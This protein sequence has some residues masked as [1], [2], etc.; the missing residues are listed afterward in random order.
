[1]NWNNKN[2]LIT[3]GAGFI[4]SNLAKYLLQNKANVTIFDNFS[5]SN[6]E[7]NLP[8]LENVAGSLQ[9]IRGDVRD[10]LAVT[11][12]VQEKD[13]IFHEAAQVAVTDSVANPIE[14]FEINARG[15]LNVL[16]AMREHSPDA[17]FVFASTNKV[18][19]G[20]E[21]FQVE[22]K[23]GRYTFS[24]EA[25]LEGVSEEINLDFHSPYGC[26]KGSADQYVRDFS[27]IYGLKTLVFR[28][29]CIY[30]QRQWGTEDQGW[31]FHFL[32]TA[33]QK[34]TIKIFGDGKQVRD[35]LY[36]DDLLRA[37]EMAIDNLETT[38]GKIY[39]VGGGLVNSVS[40]IE[41]LD[42]I[43]SILQ[44]KVKTEFFPWRPGDQKVFISNNN[45]A[46][47]DFGWSPQ[48]SVKDGIEKLYNWVQELSK[49]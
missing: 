43:E 13:F 39:N 11:K 26:S 40:L 23:N 14:D 37:Y 36:I 20:L 27:R 47:S 29:S 6:V 19:G 22:E 7:K 24:D 28:Q 32:K 16:N 17:V 9:I 21:E 2:I 18:Y 48:I 31:V 5:R 49:A 33:Y 12:A 8:W 1:M 44:S 35:L 34:E 4:G 46:L 42:V 10:E 15:T 25:L 38:S 3:G 41:A 30:G 45:K